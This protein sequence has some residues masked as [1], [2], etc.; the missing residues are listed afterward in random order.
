[1][2]AKEKLTAKIAA[3]TTEALYEIATRLNLVST[4]EA[5]LVCAL[6]ESELERRVSPEEFAA[7]LAIMEAMLD[8]AA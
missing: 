2:T 7:H 5:T 1:M 4:A 6:A 3:Q 8:A